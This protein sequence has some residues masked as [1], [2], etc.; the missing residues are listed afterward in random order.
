LSPILSLYAMGF[1]PS[2]LR[3]LDPEQLDD[4]PVAR[5]SACVRGHLTLI[6]PREEHAAILAPPLTRRGALVVVGD[7]VVFRRGDPWIVERV[8][9]HEHVLRRRDPGGGEQAIAANVDVVWVCSAVGRDLNLRR[10]ERWLALCADADLPAILVLTKADA[11]VDRGP[12]C[13]ALGSISA[14]PVVPVSALDDLGREALLATLPPGH[15]AALVGSSGVGKSTLL[16]WLLGAELQRTGAVRDDERGRHTTTR[17]RLLRL[18][19]GGWVIDNP[20]VRSVGVLDG[21]GVDAVFG[22]VVALAEGCR[23][24]DCTHTHEPGCAV[25]AAVERGVLPPERLAAWE[26]LQREL[27]WE[28]RREDPRAAAAARDA[29]KR[30]H[31]SQRRRREAADRD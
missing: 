31:M 11:G 17:R 1:T 28:A 4:P 5:V 13:A 18:P 20:G 7:W 25:Q 23:Y 19:H 21:G 22:D 14:A 3:Q 10:V 27:A 24:R 30:I 16:N 29:W 12:A 8:L 15:T 9:E 6:T 2:L 26:R